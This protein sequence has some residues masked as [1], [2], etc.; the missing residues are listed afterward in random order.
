MLFDAEDVEDAV[1]GALYND[2]FATYMLLKREK[3]HS[4]K[5]GARRERK[6]S[7]H[8]SLPRSATET[9]LLQANDRGKLPSARTQT[10]TQPSTS[11]G[12]LQ[13][14]GGGARVTFVQHAVAALAADP[15]EAS[16]IFWPPPRP[17]D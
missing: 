15:S 9:N 13:G 2:A 11:L 5:L 4:G 6:E 12:V 1:L 10:S 7:A 16:A 3:D 17:P 8:R 14:H